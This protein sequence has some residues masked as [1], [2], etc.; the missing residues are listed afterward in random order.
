MEKKE[1]SV[2]DQKLTK[3]MLY[4]PGDTIEVIPECAHLVGDYTNSI[5]IGQPYKI[6]SVFGGN[7]WTYSLENTNIHIS[8][9]H[10]RRILK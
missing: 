3:D 4:E 1:I 6:R 8:H 10:I 7:Q 2:Y 5:I 9:F